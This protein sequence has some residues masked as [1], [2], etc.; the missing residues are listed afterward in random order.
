MGD[1]EA[2]RSEELKKLGSA[3]DDFLTD[4]TADKQQVLYRS[5]TATDQDAPGHCNKVVT[6]I[7]SEKGLCPLHLA[8]D[9]EVVPRV[10]Q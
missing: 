9:S 8:A 4:I 7:L 3:F 6:D 1:D 2:L 10:L 5:C